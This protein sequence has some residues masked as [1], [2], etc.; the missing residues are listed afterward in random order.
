M[1]IKF[2]KMKI[3]T[4]IIFV[5]ISNYS[6]A[7]VD[8]SLNTPQ[9]ITELL[10]ITENLRTQNFSLFT[11]NLSTLELSKST[12]N[13]K[14]LCFF[15]YLKSYRNIY[16]GDHES[17]EN[18]LTQLFNDCNELNIKIRIKATLANHFFVAKDYYKAIV[19]LNYVILNIDN[20][21]DKKTRHIAYTISF[22][23]YERLNKNELSL[24]YI[25]LLLNDNPTEDLICKALS[26][27]YSLLLK[28][29][30]YSENGNN[31][32][33]A[34]THCESHQEYV[35]SNILKLDYLKNR[36]TNNDSTDEALKVIKELNKANLQIENTKYSNI[37]GLKNSLF[38]QAFLKA[39][40]IEK[41]IEYAHLTISVENTS[42]RSNYKS[43]ALKI[44]MKD[45]ERNQ[46]FDKAFEHLKEINTIEKSINDD[47]QAQ[48]IAYY[49]VTHENLA[50]TH[51]IN[52][53]NKQNEVLQ[54][55]NILSK[56]SKLNQQLIIL[57]LL[58][59]S[60][61]FIL[62]G[63]KHKRER[64]IFKKPFGNGSHDSYL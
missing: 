38:A 37:I 35:F 15:D 2:I 44:L 51:K 8:Q 22:L 25:D 60:A 43:D 7:D 29:N 1:N 46:D 32:L 48:T 5:T 13:N 56:E 27:K 23:V 41:A 3:I 36:L 59:A 9:E 42:G 17:A 20:T 12:L 45:A 50:N 30:H 16:I 57:S 62:W 39:G 63:Y 14:Q 21:E 58:L 31:I 34:I 49:S 28:S 6:I 52:F 10:D 11:K 19:N 53:L 40:N 33:D 4:I 18:K 54:L 55:Q 24:K 47:A 26:T 61:F 64:Q